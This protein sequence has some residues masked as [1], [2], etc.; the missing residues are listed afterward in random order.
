MRDHRAA[1]AVFFLLEKAESYKTGGRRSH[2][3]ILVSTQVCT[4]PSP[5][6]ARWMEKN[7]HLYCVCIHIE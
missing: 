2:D 1:C 6:P 7:L 4:A 5:N 3:W